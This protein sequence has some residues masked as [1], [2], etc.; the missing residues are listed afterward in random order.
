MKLSIITIVRNNKEHIETCIRSV[1]GQ[2]YKNIEY[3]VVDG[4]STDGTLDVIERF[5][6]SIDKLI[7]GKGAGVYDALNVGISAATGDVVGFLHSDDLYQRGDI[8]EKVVKKFA[9]AGCDALYGDLVYVERHNIDNVVRYWKTGE[10]SPHKFRAG[11]SIPHPTFFVKKRIYDKYGLYNTRLKI[12]SDYEMMIR[13]LYRN[14]IKASYLP[15]VLIRMRTGGISNRN[16]PSIIRKTKEDYMA[17]FI[18]GQKRAY[19]TV[20]RKSLVK[21]PQFFHRDKGRI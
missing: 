5:R 9:E 8:F 1:I 15:E 17:W 14:N 3:I 11:W 20:I 12:S 16:L 13:L 4:G 7:L 2:S 21:L 19:G 18:N 6:D 10:F